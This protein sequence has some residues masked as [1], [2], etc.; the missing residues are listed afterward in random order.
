VL[1]CEI[2]F[3]AIKTY[4]SNSSQLSRSW[5]FNALQ[6]VL[7]LLLSRDTTLSLRGAYVV[8][9]LFSTLY[10]SHCFLPSW[11]FNSVPWSLCSFRNSPVARDVLPRKRASPHGPCCL[12]PPRIHLHSSWRN[13]LDE[14]TVVVSLRSTPLGTMLVTSDYTRSFGKPAYSCFLMAGLS[15]ALFYDVDIL[16]T[17]CKSSPRSPS[18]LPT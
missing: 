12:L 15:P 17:T 2:A 4:G 6:T 8:V 3:Y 9:R 13:N 11:S 7:L 18:P 10:I 1:A 5:A 14:A 16:S